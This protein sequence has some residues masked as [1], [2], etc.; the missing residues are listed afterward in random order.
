MSTG[1]SLKSSTRRAPAASRRL[2]T[3]RHQRPWGRRLPHFLADGGR[4]LLMNDSQLKM[5]VRRFG[6]RARLQM[7]GETLSEGRESAMESEVSRALKRLYRHAIDAQY[8]YEAALGG[9]ITPRLTPLFQEMVEI[10]ARNA[11]ELAMDLQKHGEFAL[12]IASDRSPVHRP[13]IDSRAFLSGPDEGVL[14]G[15][16]DGEQRNV[17]CYNR[18]LRCDDIPGTL[19][20]HLSDQQYRL[21]AAILDMQVMRE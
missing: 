16:I 12:P 7:T 19:K 17:D 14:D 4:S 5:P 15:L 1:S 13:L 2:R 18:A 3:A 10:H 6:A 20:A 8:E 21:D 9:T 11:R